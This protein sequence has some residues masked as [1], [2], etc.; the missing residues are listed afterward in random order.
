MSKKPLIVFSVIVAVVLMS[1]VIYSSSG[2]VYVEVS[3]SD[4]IVKLEAQIE[5]HLDR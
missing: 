3:D 5:K 4:R 2:F 1:V